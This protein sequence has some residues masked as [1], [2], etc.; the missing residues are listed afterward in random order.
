M[1]PNESRNL[2]ISI[3][4]GVFATFLL[5]SYSQEKRNEIEKAAGD[6][7]R[8][9]VA[10]EDIRHMDTIY[11]NVLEIKEKLRKD[12]EPDAYENI[13]GVVGGIAAIPIKKG[14]TLTK[15]QILELGPETGMAPQVSPGKRAV[16]IPVSDDRANA[17]LIR[18]GDRVDILAIIDSGRGVNQ[19]REVTVLMQDVVIL[20]TGINVNN[21]IPRTIERDPSGRGLVQTTLTGDTR[22]NTITIEA[23]IEEAQDLVYLAATNSSSLYFLLRNPYDRKVAPRVP[24][25]SAEDIQRRI[26]P[27]G[28]SSQSPTNLAPNNGLLGR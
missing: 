5:Y 18:P 28:P 6:T 16:T 11:D 1:G 8:V 12:V 15:N 22:Y 9:V 23:R 14:Q 25:S 17:R 19:K 10:R 20:A 7:I 24:A 2:W 13:Q 21:N 4:A 3:G 27:T 26:L